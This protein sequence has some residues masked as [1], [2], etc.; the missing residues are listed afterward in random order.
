MY[1][2][3][4]DLLGNCVK[5]IHSKVVYL[6]YIDVGLFASPNVRM[7]GVVLACYSGRI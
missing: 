1:N 3:K 5:F 4:G 7:L 6:R 2:N